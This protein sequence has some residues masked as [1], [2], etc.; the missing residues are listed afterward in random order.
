MEAEMSALQRATEGEIIAELQ[1]RFRTLVMAGVYWDDNN[2]LKFCKGTHPEILGC[3]QIMSQ[4]VMIEA[5]RQS[6]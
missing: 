4:N 6:D 2:M 3:C 5:V 1:S